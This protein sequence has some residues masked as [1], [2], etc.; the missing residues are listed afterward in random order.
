MLTK[1]KQLGWCGPVNSGDH[2][3]YFKGM[4]AGVASVAKDIKINEV[5]TNNYSDVSLMASCEEQTIKS[6]ADVLTGGSQSYVG[7]IGVA[8][9]K[10]ILTFG[11]QWDQASLAPNVVVASYTYDWKGVVKDIIASHKAG[12]M[13]GKVYTATFQNGGMAIAYND[14]YK[15]DPAIKAAGDKALADLKAGTITIDLTAK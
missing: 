10:N 4:K 13:G 9:D 15:L 5:W 7:A 8:K 12:V 3:L 2:G 1:S 6:G 14:A 11:S